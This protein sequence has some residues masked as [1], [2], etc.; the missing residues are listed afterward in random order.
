[1]KK[2]LVYLESERHEDLKMLAQRHNTSMAELIRSAIEEVF[3]DDLDSMRGQR[4]LEEAA[5]DPSG[6]MS[7]EEFK[8]Q[9][10]GRVRASA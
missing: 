1:M 9:R 10:A 6:T 7:W 2:L 3:E 8:A 4:L 5:A